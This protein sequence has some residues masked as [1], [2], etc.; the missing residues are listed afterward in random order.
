MGLLDNLKLAKAGIK[1]DDIKSFNDS[2]IQTEEIIELSKNGYS[3]D[4][5][6]KLIEISADKET[7]STAPENNGS[8]SS[9]AGGDENTGDKDNFDYKKELEKQSA[10]MEKLK[11]QVKIAQ[12][13]NQHRDMGS[14]TPEKTPREILREAFRNLN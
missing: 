14:G 9:D 10:E 3:V 2:G 8:E 4:D 6:K 1:P 12:M 11:Q 5:I 7:D 13:Q